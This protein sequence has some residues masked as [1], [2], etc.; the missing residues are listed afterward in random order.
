MPHVPRGLLPAMWACFWVIWVSLSLSVPC[1]CLLVVLRV[2]GVV[3]GADHCDVEVLLRSHGVALAH[4][5][6]EV[7][8]H[9]QHRQH[10]KKIRTNCQNTLKEEK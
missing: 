8:V 5:R 7:A 10:V 6:H 9:A 2:G 3:V 4:V 1:R